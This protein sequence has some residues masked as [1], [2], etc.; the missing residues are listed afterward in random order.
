LFVLLFV[1]CCFLFFVFCFS[2][3]LAIEALRPPVMQILKNGSGD[4]FDAWR[5]AILD[6]PTRLPELQ[7]IV[8]RLGNWSGMTTSGVERT[9]AIQ[10]W[11]LDGRRGLLANA[12]ENDELKVSGP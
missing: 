9:H 5:E 12:Q 4:A 7:A 1:F 3:P 10:D 6:S 11:L 2:T 8:L